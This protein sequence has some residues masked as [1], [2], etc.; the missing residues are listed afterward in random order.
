MT[1]RYYDYNRLNSYGYGYYDYSR[2]ESGW[3][4]YWWLWLILGVLVILWIG[5]L[6]TKKTKNQACPPNARCGC[7]KTVPQTVSY[8]DNMRVGDPTPSPSPSTPPQQSTGVDY[9]NL[10]PHVR[11]NVGD[12]L[13]S[14]NWNAE[15]VTNGL[16]AW[17]SNVQSGQVSYKWLVSIPQNT[18][19]YMLLSGSGTDS[20]LAIY[21]QTN[22]P[23]VTIWPQ[24]GQTRSINPTYPLKVILAEIQ[25]FQGQGTQPIL[26]VVDSSNRVLYPTPS[27]QQSQ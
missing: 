22:T 24:S 16:V 19:S 8:A 23:I 21:D 20:N 26:E 13:V 2:E 5:G 6:L 18:A 17:P 7:S 27:R 25:Q 4:K 15:L 10:P 9:Q 11:M 12:R 14:T 1:S 3:K